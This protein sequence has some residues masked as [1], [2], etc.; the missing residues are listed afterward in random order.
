LKTGL[1][2]PERWLNRH[3]DYVNLG[4][5]FR[6]APDYVNLGGEFRTINLGGEFQPR[7]GVPE[8]PSTSEGS[9]RGV[10]RL[11]R[12]HSASSRSRTIGR[13]AGVVGAVRQPPSDV[14][15]TGAGSLVFGVGSVHGSSGVPAV[16]E[17]VKD[18]SSS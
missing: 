17:K 5:E 1:G 18:Q 9:S 3:L 7:R 6:G 10:P 14:G 4:G 11:L 2:V 15:A 12:R 13:A 8:F 16:V